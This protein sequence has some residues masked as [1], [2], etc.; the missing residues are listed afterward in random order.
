MIR[1]MNNDLRILRAMFELH[2]SGRVVDRVSLGT[3]SGVAG[4]SLVTALG[5][6]V[7]EGLVRPCLRVADV[8]GEV[9]F[10]EI[11]LTMSGLAL[12]ASF[13]P[14]LAPAR[15]ARPLRRARARSPARGVDHARRKDAA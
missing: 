2:G 12:A 1:T 9:L 14:V 3:T 4:R 10:G 8:A 15:G 6:L 5:R 13:A 11:R 7:Q